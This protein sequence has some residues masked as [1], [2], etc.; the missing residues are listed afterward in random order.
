MYCVRV[1]TDLVKASRHLSR[2]G[3]VSLV[4]ERGTPADTTLSAESGYCSAAKVSPVVEIQGDMWI[5]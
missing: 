3:F 4:E 2:N 5:L 1:V